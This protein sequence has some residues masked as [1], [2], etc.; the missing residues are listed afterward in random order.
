LFLDG[1]V[2]YEDHTIA[3]A[4]ALS[5]CFS[6]RGAQLA[7]IK[8]LDSEHVVNIHVSSISWIVKRLATYETAKNKK[9]A[10]KT[11]MFFRVLQQLVAVSMESRDALKM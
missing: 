11:L 6:L 2:D 1:L 10:K 7:I 3:L 4:R 5:S 8:R 9:M